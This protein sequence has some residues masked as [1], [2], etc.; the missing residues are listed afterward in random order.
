MDIL[1]DELAVQA[2]NQAIGGVSDRRRGRTEAGL[3]VGEGSVDSACEIRSEGVDIGV[4]SACSGTDWSI[5]LTFYVK[6]I[7]PGVS[8]IVVEG[9]TS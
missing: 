9:C 3:S 7:A 6:I 2:S 8:Q 1:A 5:C 4:G